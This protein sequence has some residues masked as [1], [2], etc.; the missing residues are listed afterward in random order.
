[1]TRP[2][3][4]HPMT[5]TRSRQLCRLLVAALVAIAIG[6]T[7]ESDAD[8]GMGRFETDEATVVAMASGELTVLNVAEGQLVERGMIVGMIENTELLAQREELRT[9]LQQLEN[10]RQMA[11]TQDEMARRR[12]NDLQKQASAL[13]QQITEVQN[14]QDHYAELYEKGVVARNQVEAFD[15]RLDMLEKQLAQIEEQIGSTVTTDEGSHGLSSDE[16][17]LRSDELQAQLSQLDQQLTGIQV[18]IPINGTVVEKKAEEGDY[19]TAGTTL[20]KIANLSKMTLRAYLSSEKSSQ[21]KIGQRVKVAV[22]TGIGSPREYNGIVTWISQ[23]AEFGGKPTATS[24]AQGTTQI[25]TDGL[26]AVKVEVVN[27][28]QIDIGMRGRIVLED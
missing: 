6:C 13:R 24:T 7:K 3:I 14:E 9:T 27:D 28:G 15:T 2:F 5:K 26:H 25:L 11:I 16:A 8:D 22:E 21:L 10:D 1:M 4:T 19:I 17:A 18:T 23:Q 12:L 20:F